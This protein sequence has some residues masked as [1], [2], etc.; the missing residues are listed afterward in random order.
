MKKILVTGGDGRFASELKKIKN[1]N[2][3]IFL[4][5]KELNILNK[6][7]ILK[8]I[9]KYKPGQ[10][11]HLGGMSRPLIDHEKN[12]I[13]SINLNIIGT[14]NLVITC[15]KFNIKIIYLSSS[16]VYEG[17]KGNY[18]E[19][20]PVL[21]WSKYGWSKL[22]AESCVQMYR[23]SLIL[24]ACM[25]EEPFL[26]K[27]AFCNVKSNFIFHKDLAKILVKILNK[28]GT[29]NIG[30]KAQTVYNFA[31]KYNKEIKKIKSNGKFPIRQDMNLTKINKI[32]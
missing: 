28:K 13:K 14:A 25:T 27:K 1:K 2:K 10:I 12:I 26:H 31:K 23:N 22:G 15:S 20:D 5:K 19:T 8:A 29:Y 3:F 32:L 9:K 16:Y 6:N 24:R 4:G 11:L 30:G 17:K 18:K 7:S 21:P